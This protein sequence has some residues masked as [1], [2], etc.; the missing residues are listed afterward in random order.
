[1]LQ[2]LEDTSLFSKKPP[3]PKSQALAFFVGNFDENEFG[4]VF[5]SVNINI[6]F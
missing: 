2:Q 5:D 4:G 3:G 1:M 6:E